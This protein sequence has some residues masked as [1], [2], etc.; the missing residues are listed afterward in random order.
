MWFDP[1]EYASSWFICAIVLIICADFLISFVGLP[2]F[3]SCCPEVA[4]GA[5]TRFHLA[6]FGGCRAQFGSSGCWT[7]LYW[8]PFNFKKLSEEASYQWYPPTIY[9]YLM[10]FFDLKGRSAVYPYKTIHSKILAANSCYL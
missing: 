2:C 9:Y 10:D 1:T 3:A 7:N 6:R 8:Q 5:L 4:S